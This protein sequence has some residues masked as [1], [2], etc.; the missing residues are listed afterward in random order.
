MTRLLRVSHDYPVAPRALWDLVTDLDQFEEM[1]GGLVTFEGLPPGR[2]SQGMVAEVRVRLFGRLPPMEY[3]MEV[4]E[5][6]DLNMRVRSSEFGAGVRSWRHSF[7][8]SA[9]PAGARLTDTIEIDAGWLTWAYA[10]WARILYRTRHGARMRLL[11]LAA[12]PRRLL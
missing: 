4:V 1:C 10:L 5:V 9:S 8:V 3:R 2:V 7:Q 11:G 6:D 12:P